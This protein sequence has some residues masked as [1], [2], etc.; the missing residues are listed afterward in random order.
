MTLYRWQNWV[1]IAVGCAAG[2]V[3]ITRLPAQVPPVQALLIALLLPFCAAVIYVS[4]AIIITKDPFNTSDTP[5][6]KTYDRI[7]FG[8]IF[9]IVAL[10]VLAVAALTGFLPPN[11]WFPRAPIILFGL[12]AI[13]VGNLLPRTRP[14]LALGIR[15][16]RT[17]WDRQAWIST[18]RIAGYLAVCLGCLYVVSGMFF[19]KHHLEAIVGP[20]SIAA[21]CLLAVQ[22]LRS[23]TV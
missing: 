12:L 17:L 10:Q 16:R 21:A 23:R 19:S 8:V 5:L 2:I 6:L 22:Y 4:A 11:P 13:W 1:L 9:F 15:T 14:N 18:H 7:L 20:V 3:G